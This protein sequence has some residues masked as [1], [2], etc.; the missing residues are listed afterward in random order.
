MGAD[1]V[2]DDPAEYNELSQSQPERLQAMMQRYSELRP[3]LFEPNRGTI[4]PR[5]C[6]V[7]INRYGGFW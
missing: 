4:D 2:A 5:A 6:D 1:N 3:S 7:A